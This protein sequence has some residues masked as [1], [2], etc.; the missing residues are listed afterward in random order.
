MSKFR[1][2]FEAALQES[3]LSLLLEDFK[4]GTDI[5]KAANKLWNILNTGGFKNLVNA[6]MAKHNLGVVTNIKT[7]HVSGG[8]DPVQGVSLVSLYLLTTV[9]YPCVPVKG[10]PKVNAKITVKTRVSDHYKKSEDIQVYVPDPV[11]WPNPT[12]VIQGY[13][14]YDFSDEDTTINYIKR[15]YHQVATS[16]LQQCHKIKKLLESLKDPEI[17][18]IALRNKSKLSDIDAG[19]KDIDYTDWFTSWIRDCQDI[20]KAAM[21]QWGYAR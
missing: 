20:D 15:G 2:L 13:K 11:K 14:K 19:F 17:F 9:T 12:L 7:E 21:S 3:N 1:E 10:Y 16:I 8:N 5:T 6:E 18:K 4:T